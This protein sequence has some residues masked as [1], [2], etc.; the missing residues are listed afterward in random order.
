MGGLGVGWACWQGE[1]MA[2]KFSRLRE[3][4]KK[5]KVASQTPIDFRP[6]EGSTQG[7]YFP[8][9]KTIG[10][11]ERLKE[12]PLYGY[13]AEE[14][15]GHELG[16]SIWNQELDPFYKNFFNAKF[17][18]EEAQRRRE[19]SPLKQKFTDMLKG[20][21][22]FQLPSLSEVYPGIREDYTKEALGGYRV[23]TL[24]KS[25]TRRHAGHPFADALGKFLTNPGQLPDDIY[26]SLLTITGIDPRREK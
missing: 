3:M 17:T 14:I 16:H 26:N 6:F 18:P 7:E 2:D 5:Y 8:E 25:K 9:S 13:T 15:A 20:E 24:G 10:I 12:A 11:N 1:V 4:L 22:R 21:N 23:D 19:L